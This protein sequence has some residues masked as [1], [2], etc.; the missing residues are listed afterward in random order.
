MTG[1]PEHTRAHNAHGWKVADAVGRYPQSGRVEH[2]T[3]P[4][5]IVVVNS[6]LLELLENEA[7]LAAVVGHEI[8]HSTHEHTWRQQQYHKKTRIGIAIAGA[9]AGAYGLRSLADMSNMVNAAIVNGHQRALENQSDRIGL[10]YMVAAGYDPREAPAIWKLM[11]Q[12]S[13]VQATDFFWSNHDNEPTRRS[14]LMNE[15]KNNYRD[16]DYSSL[17]TDAD[18]YAKIKA[19]VNAASGTKKKIKVTS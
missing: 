17:R 9:V 2:G 1:K 3:T 18:R 13:G 8:A 11:A 12:K 19:A 16:L 14:Y 4:N 10:Q 5:G 7:Q 15:L 6:G